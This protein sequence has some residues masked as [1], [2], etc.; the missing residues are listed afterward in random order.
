MLYIPAYWYHHV[1]AMIS[2]AGTSHGGTTTQTEHL[3]ISA[4]FWSTKSMP[5]LMAN[6]APMPFDSDFD[7]D[8]AEV[9]RSQFPE[10]YP[11]DKILQASRLV[12]LSVIADELFA[13]GSVA[14]IARQVCWLRYRDLFGPAPEM[15]SICPP[16]IP[17]SD[18]KYLQKAI[19]RHTGVIVDGLRDL[20]RAASETEFL[21]IMEL[22]IEEAVPTA[23]LY[24]FLHNCFEYTLGADPNAP[25]GFEK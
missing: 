21:N 8:E 25:T 24:A 7:A 15:T 18:L 5:F 17:A 16:R 20:V 2:P 3:S 4:N 10:S 22:S 1:E 19:K 6:Q 12:T 14:A 13:K 11:D 9:I 23:D